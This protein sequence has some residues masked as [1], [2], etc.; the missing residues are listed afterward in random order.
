MALTNI[1]ERLSLYY[2]LEARLETRETTLPDGRREYHVQVFLP[3][4]TATRLKEE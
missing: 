4:R 1:R 3:C 2:D